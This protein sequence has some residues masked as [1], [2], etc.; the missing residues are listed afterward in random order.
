MNLNR[1]RQRMRAPLRMP[2]WLQRWALLLVAAAVLSGC[3][4]LAPGGLPLGTP[5][6][7]ARQ[8]WFGP[9]A[10]YPL[11]GGGTRLEFDQGSFG[12]QT[13]MLDFNAE[14]RLVASHQVLNEANFAT[15]TP[16]LSAA[17]VL[18]RLGHPVQVFPVGWQKLQVWN[19]RYPGGDC[20]WF[21]VSI[22]DATQRVTEAGMGGDPACDAPP[23]RIGSR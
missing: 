11:P 20:V 18:M 19:Y 21:Q 3:A 5:I 13:Y 15:I 4:A 23:D 16:G 22:S 2:L 9:A 17:E 1:C 14:G 12:R 7:Q 6:A 8:A 10:E